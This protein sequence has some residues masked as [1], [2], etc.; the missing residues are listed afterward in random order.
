MSWSCP[1][2]NWNARGERRDARGVQ[3]G[4]PEDDRA[5]PERH[6]PGDGAAAGPVD[7]R[8]EGH[9]LPI[10]GRVRRAVTC[11]VVVE[12]VTIWV[13]DGDWLPA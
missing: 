2:G 9:R 7:R 4:G 3:G 5:R 6:G 12:R 13:S 10:G 11:V 8:G 1:P